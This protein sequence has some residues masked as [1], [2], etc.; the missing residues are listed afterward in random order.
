VPVVKFGSAAGVGEALDAE[1]NFGQVHRGSSGD[2]SQ[3]LALE[4]WAAQLGKDIGHCEGR[5]RRSNPFFLF[6]P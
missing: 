5:L 6:A 3:Y 1:P 2:E 4:F